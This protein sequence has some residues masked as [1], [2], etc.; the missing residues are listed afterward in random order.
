M[1]M[2]IQR[3]IRSTRSARASSLTYSIQ[4]SIR[5]CAISGAVSFR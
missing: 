1:E 2:N 3:S 5:S 4:S